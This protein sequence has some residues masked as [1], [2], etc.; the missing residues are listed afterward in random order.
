MDKTLI[1]ISPP[2]ILEY[3]EN[4]CKEF[5]TVNTTIERNIAIDNLGAFWVNSREA[6]ENK[7][8]H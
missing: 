8:K 4:I 3:K 2:E 6:E 5:R 1:K 7:K